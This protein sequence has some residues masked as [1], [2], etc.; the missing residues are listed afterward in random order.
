MAIKEILKVNRK[1]FI[2]PR[3]WLGYDY[4]KQQTLGIWGAVK[5]VFNRNIEVGKDETFEQAKQRLNLTDEEINTIGQNYFLY[6]LFYALL[7]IV[8]LCFAVYL[9][10]SAS[11]AG[12][13]I[14]VSL[15]VFLFGQAFRNHFWSF[16]IKYRKLGCTFEEWR[17]GKPNDEGKA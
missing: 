12:F 6:A 2:N 5:G 10:V 7:G 9:L 14:A 8:I 1:T 13:M 4:V 16:Q 11:L 15:S 17:S 3:A